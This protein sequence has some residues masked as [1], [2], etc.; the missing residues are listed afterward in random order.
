DHYKGRLMK[1]GK[2]AT[3]KEMAKRLKISPSTGSR[4]L[5]VHPSIG[6]VTTMRVK[7]VAEEL[8]YEPNQTAIFFKPRKTFTL[9]VV[10]LSLSEPF[11]SA[12][13]SEIENVASEK[14]YTVI[15]GQ[16]LDD[17]KRELRILQTLKTHRVDGVLM[18]IGKNTRD[19][20]FIELLESA[21]IPM[22]F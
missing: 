15:M 9:G 18:S 8:N 7:K 20:P 11:F 19:Y 12:A 16:S 14:N 21:G 6:L 13:I 4:A 5:N 1:E 2:P 22:V 3:I 10:L 17:A